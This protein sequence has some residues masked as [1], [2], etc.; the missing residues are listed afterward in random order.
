MFLALV[1]S[2]V[3]FAHKPAVIAGIVICGLGLAVSR[4]RIDSPD[5]YLPLI[6][7][8]F[9]HGRLVRRGPGFLAMVREVWGARAYLRLSGICLIGVG[10]IGLIFSD[11]ATHESQGD[12]AT[13]FDAV[14]SCLLVLGAVIV[15]YLWVTWLIRKLR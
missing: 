13:A 9:S 11:G 3:Y 12:V 6:D 4:M 2:T 14:F 8:G 7:D 5:A 1:F 15:I 10:I